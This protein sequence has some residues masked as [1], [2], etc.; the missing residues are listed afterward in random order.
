MTKKKKKE[1]KRLR[2]RHT[3]ET[4]RNAKNK[5]PIDVKVELVQIIR[6][7]DPTSS[8]QRKKSNTVSGAEKTK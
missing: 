4:E 8:P 6:G 7:L 1:K 3:Q 2:P 5:Y